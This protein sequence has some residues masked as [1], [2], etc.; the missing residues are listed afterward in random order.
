MG[1]AYEEGVE[2]GAVKIH[3][4]RGIGELLILETL[5]DR[6]VRISGVIWTVLRTLW[7]AKLTLRAFF[8]EFQ[9]IRRLK[10]RIWGVS[11]MR[12]DEQDFTGGS[13]C[14][15]DIDVPVQ[16][17]SVSFQQK[18]PICEML[19]TGLVLGLSNVWEGFGEREWEKAC[20]VKCGTI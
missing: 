18:Q 12:Q 15:F 17:R 7:R 8:R 4:S 11:N 14:F 9:L 3:Y 6:V 1:S 20:V 19:L 13:N 5:F 16:N 2:W 10:I